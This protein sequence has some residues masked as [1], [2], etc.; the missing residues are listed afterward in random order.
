M[1]V[2]GYA[3]TMAML[4]DM[5]E[6]LQH[7]MIKHRQDRVKQM[8]LSTDLDYVNQSIANLRPQGPILTEVLAEQSFLNDEEYT[9]KAS[10]ARWRAKQKERPPVSTAIAAETL[11]A[12][13]R[14]GRLVDMAIQLPSRRHAVAPEPPQPA[15]QK[16]FSES[17]ITHFRDLG[18]DESYLALLQGD[19][20]P[21][22][23]E[24]GRVEPTPAQSEERMDGQTRGSS[25]STSHSPTKREDRRKEPQKPQTTSK[26]HSQEVTVTNGPTG[27][28]KES[29]IVGSSIL[30]EEGKLQSEPESPRKKSTSTLDEKLA[31]SL[32][33]SKT[34]PKDAG[35]KLVKGKLSRTAREY[36]VGLLKS[37]GIEP[38]EEII[39]YHGPYW[40]ALED[41]SALLRTS[42]PS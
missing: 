16:E 4:V 9:E 8:Q 7:S 12:E 24:A 26:K 20:D 31:Q 13:Q 32:Q 11:L 35:W 28:Q 39:R 34:A 17:T 30:P 15:V 42:K 1:C 6:A 36:R 5:S 37:C 25:G 21:F 29:L 41:V 27:V 38:T 18:L 40:K 22:L 14:I 2:T 23:E 19:L 10:A 3:K 33:P